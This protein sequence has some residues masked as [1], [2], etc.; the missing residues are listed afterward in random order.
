MFRAACELGR[1]DALLGSSLDHLTGIGGTGLTRAGAAA[2]AVGEALERY[3]ASFV[4]ADRLVFASA[5][6]LGDD[7]VPP[8]RFALF[9]E[10]QY[11][12]P[13]F[14]YRRFTPGTKIAWVEGQSLPDRARAFLPAELVF[15]AQV[16]AEG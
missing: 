5:R 7:A 15:L 9:S 8:E 13:G 14:P 10:R 3:S 12:Q 2:A 11:A 1:A 4:P 16:A 6:E